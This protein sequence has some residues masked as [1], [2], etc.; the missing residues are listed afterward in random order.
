[1]SKVFQQLRDGQP[2][3]MR[4]LQ[5]QEVIHELH[6]ADLALYKLNHTEPRS[7]QQKMA[8]NELFDGHAPV[9]VGVMM[10]VQIDFPKQMKFGHGVFINHHFT[11]MAIGGITI[12]DNVQIGPNVTMATD[13]HDLVNHHLLK[14]RPIFIQDNVWIGAN[15]TIV[16][17]VTVSKN[18]V[19][20]A[21]AV[22]TRDVPANTV[23]A[24]TPARV[25]RK[26]EGGTPAD[27]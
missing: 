19:I 10:P 23:V 4:S 11:A 6:R 1:M 8:W 20:A 21:G 14:C 27:A 16:P 15:A 5:Y 18:S 3:D 17:G 22:V 24:G 9:G 25:I 2:I 13:N 26:L 7:R 12:G